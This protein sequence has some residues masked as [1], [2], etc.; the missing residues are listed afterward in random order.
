MSSIDINDDSD[1]TLICNGFMTLL[2]GRKP[3]MESEACEKS[4]FLTD[5]RIRLLSAEM[6]IMNSSLTVYTTYP[7][8]SSCSFQYPNVVMSYF[9]ASE[10]LLSYNF[11]AAIP[12]M[13]RWKVQ[14]YTRVSDILRLALAH[15]F[16]KTYIDTDIV[17]LQ[18]NE[19]LYMKSFVSACIWRDSGAAIEITNSAFCLER[20]ILKEMMSFQMNRIIFGSDSYMYTELGPSMF[21]KILLNN[22]DILL[23]SQNSPK[24]PRP[25]QMVRNTLTYNYALLHLT[26]SI[27][28]A[29]NQNFFHYINQIRIRL[30]LT[31]LHIPE[32]TNEIFLN[33]N[34][35]DQNGNKKLIE[36]QKDSI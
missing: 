7:L 2:A 14:G 24:D 32:S 27:R 33:R 11:T 30:N 13:S 1:S 28:K 22:H 18:L 16:Q 17:F 12:R 36:D 15:R 35:L 31:R 9:N 29:W 5:E 19:G 20:N 10:L 25:L 21:H 4:T 3:W 26:T 6:T 8:T 34:H 23:Y